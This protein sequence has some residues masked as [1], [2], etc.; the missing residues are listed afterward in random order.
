VVEG[1]C[2]DDSVKNVD[3]VT[4]GVMLKVVSG[5]G[6][7]KIAGCSTRD[8]RHCSSPYRNKSILQHT[9]G[10]IRDATFWKPVVA[11]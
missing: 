7:L 3:L 5:F 9:D 2:A 8:N 4:V 11:Q 10:K 6:R 1:S